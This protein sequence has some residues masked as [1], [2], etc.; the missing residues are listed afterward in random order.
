MGINE[1]LAV[2]V[3]VVSLIV[4]FAGMVRWLVKHY[5]HELV[6]NSGSSM[7]DRIMRLEYDL[8]EI[9]SDVKEIYK[10]LIERGP[11]V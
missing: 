7:K 4:S 11:N 8:L 3:A 9:R 10:L 5:L 2:G 6:P 1:W